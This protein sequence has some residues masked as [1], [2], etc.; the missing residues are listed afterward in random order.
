MVYYVR[1][2]FDRAIPTASSIDR[3]TIGRMG[4]WE[5]GWGSGHLE[6]PSDEELAGH[7]C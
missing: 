1:D 2:G 3:H 7:S 5:L 4:G 6:V